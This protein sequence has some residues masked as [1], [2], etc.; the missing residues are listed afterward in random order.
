VPADITQSGSRRWSE[1]FL[2]PAGGQLEQGLEAGQVELL[3]DRREAM[4]F[5]IV[6]QE[7]A[8]QNE[9]ETALR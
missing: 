3:A 4:R 5:R 8:W 9:V 2:P 1:S 7:G 6:I